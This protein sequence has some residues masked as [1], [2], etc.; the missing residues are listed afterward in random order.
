MT[1]HCIAVAAG[2]TGGHFFPAEALSCELVRRGHDIILMT[3]R[4][5]G[6]RESG[7]FASRQQFVLPGG[8]IAGRGAVRAARAAFALARGTMQARRILARLRP[9]A[10]IGFGGYPSVPPLLGGSLLPRAIRPML[11]VHEGNAVLGKANGFLAS[12]MDAIATSFSL[13]AGVPAAIP[14]TL[15]GM[16]VRPD[17]A[18]LAAE[19]Y[20]PSNGVINLLVWGGSLGARVFSD[21]VPTALAALPPAL[22]AR[23]QVTQQARAEDVARVSAAYAT[24]GIPAHVAPFLDDVP[25]RLRTAHLVIGRAGGSS[26]AELTVAGRP[27]LLVP[28]PIAARDEQGANAQALSDA[29]AAWMIRQ[30]D[31]TAPALTDR[32]T[33]LLGDRDLLARTAQ[34]AA[35]LGRPDAATRLADM[36]EAR[37]PE[38]PRTA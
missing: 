25:D 34:A 12:R 14:T 37:L 5:A 32:L 2:G 11:F 16:P 29:G 10:V 28:L 9:S 30:P 4:R 21:V 27:S 19:G 8:G 36:I 33:A 35:S 31:F 22:R 18:A 1:R 6:V 13:V 26:V 3:D 38:Q 20:S 7:I 23:I 24:A 15:T 17:I